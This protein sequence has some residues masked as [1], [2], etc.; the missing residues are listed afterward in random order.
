MHRPF[1]L[2]MRFDSCA[3]G[4]LLK[5]FREGQSAPLGG[6]GL[7]GIGQSGFMEQDKVGHHFNRT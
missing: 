1:R 4:N 6:G 3:V 5:A 7:G 2:Q